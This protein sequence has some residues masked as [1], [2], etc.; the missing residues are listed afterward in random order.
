MLLSP[1]SKR[2]LN[3]TVNILLLT[4]VPPQALSNLKWSIRKLLQVDGVSIYHF[5]T[6]FLFLLETFLSLRKVGNKISLQEIKIKPAPVPKPSSFT[7]LLSVVK[8]PLVLQYGSDGFYSCLI[9]S[10]FSPYVH[11]FAAITRLP[12][13]CWKPYILWQYILRM[14][15]VR[16]LLFVPWVLQFTLNPK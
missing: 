3:L 15:V 10:S 1:F 7:V 12:R 6:L 2:H 9:L 8:G 16:I 14:T 11:T 13:G 5:I 4:V